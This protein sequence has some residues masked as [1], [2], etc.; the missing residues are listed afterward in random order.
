[1]LVLVA[2]VVPAEEPLMAPDK[3]MAVKLVLAL[4][5]GPF[6][7]LVMVLFDHYSALSILA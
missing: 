7:T 3:H 2:S 4:I 6:E 1:M 5:V